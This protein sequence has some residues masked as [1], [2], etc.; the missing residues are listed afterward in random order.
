VTGAQTARS[1]HAGAIDGQTY[2]GRSRIVRYV[3]LVKLPHTVFALP[4]ALLGV[5]YASF[6][7]VVSGRVLGL[8][9]VAFTAARFAAMGFNRIV[10]R[11]FDAANPRTSLREL[12]AGGLSVREAW[13][14][15]VVAA[16]GF[17]GSA[18]LLNPVCLALSPLA[19][20]WILGYS[21][22]KR[23]THWSHLW[24]GGSLAIAPVAG[25][26]AVAG[27]WDAPWLALLV[28]AFAVLT[29]VAG[30]DIFYALQDQ[31]FDRRVGLRSAVVL[32]GE[33]R[34][35]LV[36]KQLHG[37]TIAMLAAF[38]VFTPFGAV[39]FLG[40]L[41]AAGL[42]AWEHRLVRPGDLTHLDAAFFRMNGVMSLV[43]LVFALGDRV[44]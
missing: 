28:V 33:H 25:Y 30:F 27:R 31:D 18:A 6:G 29:W 12:P 43:V 5:V 2:R 26:L 4:F 38:G 14:A 20:A 44:L 32:L 8:V 11:D 1:P 13:V 3:N 41:V 40:V 7:Y 34:S 24:L 21:F 23:F 17:V 9:A 22:T 16:L 42:L 36:G 35:I 37:A 19:L 15:V 39:Y 10:D